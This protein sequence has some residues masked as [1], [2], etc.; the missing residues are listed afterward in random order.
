MNWDQIE[1]NWKQIKGDVK[2]KWGELT[3][4]EIDQASGKRENLVGLIQERYG[5]AKEEAEREIDH[6]FAK[7][8]LA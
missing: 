3:E 8:E 1:G 2:A 6:F 4:D 5:K 7:H